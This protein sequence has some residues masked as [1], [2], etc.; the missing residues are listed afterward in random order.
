[1]EPKAISASRGP[2]VLE[3]I[4]TTGNFF[5]HRINEP[6]AIEVRRLVNQFRFLARNT[7]CYPYRLDMYFSG[8]KNLLPII[9]TLSYILK[10]GLNQLITLNV[11]DPKIPNFHYDL[12]VR[13][14]IGDSTRITDPSFPYLIPARRSARING[15]PPENFTGDAFLLEK[16]DTVF[17]MRKGTVTA[18]VNMK[19]DADRVDGKSAVE[20]YQPDGS[21]LIYRNMNAMQIFVKAGDTIYP[22]QPLGLVGPTNILEVALFDI[23]NNGELRQMEISYF[24]GRKGIRYSSELEARD[25][26]GYPDS[27]VMKELTER[28]SDQFKK[29]DLYR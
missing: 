14:L 20:I 23:L 12:S 28:E 26:S 18:T 1:M 27:L 6:V 13:A 8:L 15:N 16:A 22:G 19:E 4:D 17:A 7:S 21:V 3:F 29:G 9:D 10:P 24:A 2:G 5:Y 11:I 25:L